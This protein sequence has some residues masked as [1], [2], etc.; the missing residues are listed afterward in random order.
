MTTV[1]ELLAHAPDDLQQPGSGR[2]AERFEALWDLG[3]VSPRTARLLEAHYDARA[4]LREAG[5]TPGEGRTFG[6]W[7][8]GGPDPATLD[9]GG[10]LRGSKHWCSGA[11]LVSHALVSV[12]HG[13]SNALVEV[14]LDRPG[15][16]VEPSRWQS[17]AFADV[18]TR[19]V[20]FDL[21]VDDDDVVGIDDWYLRRP[22]FWHGAIGVAA[23]WAGCA[24]GM[25]RRLGERWPDDPH[26]HAHLGAIDGALWAM[27]AAV[28]TA[29]AEIDRNPGQATE[30]QQRALRVRHLVDAL[31][32][33][34]TARAARAVGPGPLA[35]D[36][37][38]HQAM[39]E[40]DLYRRQCHAERDLEVLG[41]LRATPA[42]GPA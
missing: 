24:D 39:I 13:G 31:V 1:A 40:S 12:R 17:P 35:H 5:R 10:R 30:R 27:R 15:V 37:G 42:G 14:A 23:C 8:A 9:D 21:V 4:I 41:R 6:V 26:A 38:V 29:A 22:G 20:R 28:L 2:T 16:T 18:D 34:I 25:V 11:S 7:A 32:A 36:A 3:A 33:E 19:T